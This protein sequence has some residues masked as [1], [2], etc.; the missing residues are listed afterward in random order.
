M[1][2][3]LDLLD[4]I[5]TKAQEQ[6]LKLPNLPMLDANPSKFIGNLVV[7]YAVRSIRTLAAD[8]RVDESKKI[9][10]FI[11]RRA[12]GTSHFRYPA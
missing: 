3:I 6:K 11:C 7:D 12:Q 9:N 2:R 5:P 8:P 4:D 1:H 10:G